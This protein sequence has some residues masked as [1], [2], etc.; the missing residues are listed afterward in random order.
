MAKITLKKER[1][2]DLDT[3]FRLYVDDVFITP[4][5]DEKEAV[6]LYQ[7]TLLRYKEIAGEEK[8]I[9]IFEETT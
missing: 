2:N 8:S 7:K 5:Y 9:I 6:E 3:V 1:D 4:R